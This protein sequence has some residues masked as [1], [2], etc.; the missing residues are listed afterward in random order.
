MATQHINHGCEISP[1]EAPWLGGAGSRQNGWIKPVQIHGEINRAAGPG[2]HGI[3]QGLDVIHASTTAVQFM[4]FVAG[5]A[6]NRQLQQVATGQH[7]QAAP[8]GAGVA[9]AGTEPLLSEIGMGIQLHQ[10]QIG[11]LVGNGGHGAGA[12]RMLT[13]Q[14]QG[15]QTQI[16]HR[17]CGL[18]HGVHDRFGCTEGDVH[19]TEIGIGQILQ[20][21]IQLRAIGF[22][23][24]ADLTDRCRS[25]TGAWPEG[26]GAVVGNAE[27]AD[28]A[29]GWVAPGSHEDAAFAVERGHG[30]NSRAM[31]AGMASR[32]PCCQR[33]L[34]ISQPSATRAARA[35]CTVR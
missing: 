13:A 17:R 12:D 6:A 7:L 14:H 33:G 31:K 30:A 8:H 27:Q 18:L 3:P 28:A 19:S 32:A 16:E 1:E 29:A 15:V 4:E 35:G 10:H 34:Q 25:E 20:I 5:A 21:Q 26:G 9:V 23:A 11:M 2:G 24:L 22:Q